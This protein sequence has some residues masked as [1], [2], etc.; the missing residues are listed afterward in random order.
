MQMSVK[1]TLLAAAALTALAAPVMAA[2]PTPAAD[3]CA[4]MLTVVRDMVDNP[5]VQAGIAKQVG[6]PVTVGQL[7][8]ADYNG[9]QHGKQALFNWNVCKS[10]PV[11]AAYILAPRPADPFAQV[12]A[13]LAD[14]ADIAIPH[15]DVDA[16]C[17]RLYAGVHNGYKY[18]MNHEQD[19]YHLLKTTWSTMHG[20][21]SWCVQHNGSL[22][23]Y[24]SLEDCVLKNDVTQAQLDEM[25]TSRPF[26]Y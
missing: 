19:A 5:K 14:P 16:T 8:V 23:S 9:Y 26:R 13:M 1:K 2:Q 6:H 17:R 22:Q 4:G 25:T 3:D 15:Y 18:C 21:R 7:L 20:G 11:L 10:D 12:R 24:Q